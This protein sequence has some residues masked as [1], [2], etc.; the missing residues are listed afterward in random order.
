MVLEGETKYRGEKKEVETERERKESAAVPPKDPPSDIESQ[1]MIER[2][3]GCVWRGGGLR[4][5]ARLS[6][7][8][9]IRNLPLF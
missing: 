8:R 3:G 7:M 4:N 6:S 2:G 1:D 9:K 5:I